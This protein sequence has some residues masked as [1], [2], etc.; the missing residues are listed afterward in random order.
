M[1][2]LVC[3]EWGWAEYRDAAACLAGG[4]Q[5]SG[6]AV[7]ALLDAFASL[8]PGSVPLPVNRGRVAL[9]LALRA[10]ARLK[11]GKT[12]V[13]Y[14]AYIC[15]SV[16]AAIEAAGLVPVPADIGPDL[17]M[18]VAQ[19]A[20]AVG[21][22]TLAIVAV[23]IYGCPAPVAEFQEFC[24]ARRLFLIDDAACLVGVEGESGRMLGA[25][26]DAGVVSFTA[27]KS[28][29]AGGFNA[30]GLLLVNNPE[31][32]P[33]LRREWA[34]LPAPRFRLSDFLLFLRDQQLETYSRAVCYYWSAA[35]RRLS[36][37]Y[38]GRHDCP[39]SR[40]ANISALLATTQLGS[41]DRR[42]AGRIRIAEEFHRALAAVP[43][44]GFPQ[45]RAGR[46]L[47]RIVL[48]LPPGAGLGRVRA[49]LRRQGIE[50]RR[51]YGLDLRHGK[52]FPRALALA[53]QLIE[54][55]SHSRMDR[56]VIERIC[57][58]LGKSAGATAVTAG[59]SRQ[60][61]AVA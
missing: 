57:A 38:D 25:F 26:G 11:P 28:I 10:F 40:I 51:G 18:G 39:P 54:V 33:A 47:T 3:A 36:R 20:R 55:P 15:A 41:L 16:I 35:R 29:V 1:Q 37:R 17:N 44:I 45:Y 4:R 46:Y 48:Q 61:A 13:V 9:T 27:S 50:T 60:P 22:N 14:P 52:A 12:E 19:A 53:P 31:L 6:G 32:E 5:N 21:E 42:V 24:R 23:H 34:A 2:R 58:A 30:G 8:Y 7:A 59:Q 43:E 49:G 56:A